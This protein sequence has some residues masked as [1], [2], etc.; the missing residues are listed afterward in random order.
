MMPCYSISQILWEILKINKQI[1]GNS[2]VAQ[3]LRLQASTTGD[4]DSIPGGTTKILHA[5]G[6]IIKNKK[7]KHHKRE[8]VISINEK[9]EIDLDI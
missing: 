2:L 9:R 7:N 5:A 6:P 4:T 3:W 8:W 1:S